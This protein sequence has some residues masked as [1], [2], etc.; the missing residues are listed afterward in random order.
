MHR[1]HW[2]TNLRS[3]W[4]ENVGTRSGS[5]PG[6]SR[7][8]PSRRPPPLFLIKRATD[9]VGSAHRAGGRREYLQHGSAAGPAH[10]R[11]LWA[12]R[13]RE[14]AI[15]V[16]LDQDPLCPEARLQVVA[17]QALD[18]VALAHVE[19]EAVRC[20]PGSSDHPL[21]SGKREIQPAL[22]QVDNLL[23]Q[24]ADALGVQRQ[25]PSGLRVRQIL[26]GE[27][28]KPPLELERVPEI[29]T[30]RVGPFVTCHSELFQSRFS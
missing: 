12:L 2:A 26:K 17:E 8:A 3:E 28:E 5:G 25:D 7:A 30:L 9:S 18:R 23:Y 20:T 24:L 11:G 6:V 10:A 15:E 21:G 4:S 22:L 1:A 29:S 19:D 13:Q 16:F 14:G 27:A